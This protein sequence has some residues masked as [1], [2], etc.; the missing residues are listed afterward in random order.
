MALAIFFR[1]WDLKNTPPGLWSDE[2]MN[3]INTIQATEGGP[4][5]GRWKVFY[6]EN[7]GREGLFINIQALFVKTLGHESWVLRLPSAI[8]G[9]L[10]VLGLFLMTKELFSARIALFSA[11]FM[12]T[13]FWHV[14][15]SRIGFRAIMA[16][17]FLVWGFYFVL[18]LMREARDEK[19]PGGGAPSRN[20]ILARLEI[21][22]AIAGFIFGL[23]IHSYIAYR[24]APLIVLY[25]LWIFYKQYRGGKL[26]ENACAPCLIVL[27]I[28]MTLVAASP[29]LIYFGQNPADFLGRTAGISIFNAPNPLAQFSEN[30]AK[31]LQMFN[32]Y[33]DFNWRHNYRGAPQLWWPVGILFLI[34][35]W[36]S[37]R[38]KKQ[39][40][41]YRFVLIWSVVMFL[42]VVMS[43]EGLPHALRAI[44]LI[45]PAMIFAGL[46]METVIIFM[47]RLIERW[48]NRFPEKLF[49]IARIEQELKI[50]LFIF[51]FAVI[52]NTFNSYFFKW[53]ASGDVFESFL[54]EETDIARW[55][56]E[57][58][59]KIKKYVVTNSVD[60][61]D[62]TGRPLSFMPIVFITDTYFQNKQNEKNIFYAGKKEFDKIDCSTPCAII[63]VESQPTIYAE[64]KEKIP[65]LRL[66]ADL[67]FIV[68]R[69]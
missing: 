63:P 65:N 45:P 12:A 19:I 5:A 30:T 20:I 31:T 10:T 33:G 1:L 49:Q 35:I 68:L 69:N 55:L 37:L 32:F 60:T 23:G 39:R 66:G 17:F 47:N 64:L 11:F 40:F 56:N 50:L 2:A 41:S 54:G 57:A 6:P 52:V 28:F 25:P 46:G 16:P 61:V 8:F 18:R 42:P 26:K 67:G 62:L 14:N 51:L 13:S 27:F 48:K 24:V 58:P 36:K 59:K 38:I 53:G 44:V 34:G 22:A 3:G 4:P 43:S 15:F 21:L 9:I 7:F 29:L